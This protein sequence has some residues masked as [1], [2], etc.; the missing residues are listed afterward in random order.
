[1]A[2]LKYYDTGTSTWLPILVGAQ[3]VQG[4]TG[5][6]GTTGAGTQGTTGETG[7][8]GTTGTQ[9]TTGQNGNF[10]GASFD[11]TYSTTTAAADPGAGKI[12]FN[13]ATI[14]SATAMYI[15]STNDAATDLSSFLNTIDDSTSTIKGHFRVSAKFD[16]SIFALFTISSLVDQTGWFTVNGSYVSGNG[17]F[18]DLA[19]TV[20]TFARTGD[21]GD[22]G[23]QGT[24]GAQGTVG[25]QGTEGTQGTEGAQGVSGLTGYT[26]PTLGSTSIASGS[27]TASVS[28]LTLINGDIQN[29][30]F[31][32]VAAGTGGISYSD[33]GANGSTNWT[34]PVEEVSFASVAF[35][36]NT[37]VAVPTSGNT[38]YYSADGV[39]WKTS[40][41]PASKSWQSI[42]FTSNAFVAI[43]S[44]ASAYSV[45][46]SDGIT[47]TVTAT[48]T[49][50]AING[51]GGGLVYG[52]NGVIAFRTPGNG[53]R[54]T[55]NGITWTST[56]IPAT[57]GPNYVS[58]AYGAGKYVVIAGGTSTNLTA[59]SS[60]GTSWTVGA[61]PTSANW[62]GITFGNGKF[63]AV[64][65]GTDIA[66]YS[67]DGINWTT[68]TMSR[69][70]TWKLITY[71]NNKYVVV[72]TSG[73]RMAQSVDG[74][75]WTDGTINTAGG[76]MGGVIYGLGTP[77]SGTAGQV[78]SSSGSAL[79]WK[80]TKLYTEIFTVDESAAGFD[81]YNST[82]WVCPAGVTQIHAHLIGGGG[83]SGAVTTTVYTGGSNFSN[84]NG[85]TD[86]GGFSTIYD[87]TAD[88]YLAQAAGGTAGYSAVANSGT[89]PSGTGNYSVDT[90]SASTNQYLNTS[91]TSQNDRPYGSGGCD[92]I[93]KIDISWTMTDSTDNFT[94][95]IATYVAN[96]GGGNPGKELFITLAVVPGQTYYMAGGFGGGHAYWSGGMPGSGT[97]IKN[98]NSPQYGTMGAVIIRYVKND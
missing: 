4:N 26:A 1:M 83:S 25:A 20:I 78:L 55:N 85:P 87:V 81:Y 31:G 91:L 93:G 75:S 54:S 41:L 14:T 29:Y 56:T 95:P 80:T 19:D 11:Y 45:R 98:A 79:T 84:T 36:N 52:T 28:D 22:T 72:A 39:T 8:Q 38:G 44:A 32:F 97:L 47:W 71:G 30:T 15:D 58:A 42:V 89:E 21:K 16:D 88:A 9:G 70:S 67:T 90:Y 46:S 23:T 43:D 69:S 51:T 86:S 73:S 77:A 12:R 6:Q 35:G 10:G 49:A 53:S 2:Q 96:T 27:T 37:W 50:G 7:A 76:T 74:I 40:T 48:V 82:A 61:L 34:M 17:S 13:N 33:T 24:E 94:L 66:A 92:N 64:A 62:Q 59:Y 60:N 5:T 68:S 57:G 18:S 63:V 3:G 65:T